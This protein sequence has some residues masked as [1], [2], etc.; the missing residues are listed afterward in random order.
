MTL[1]NPKIAVIGFGAAAIGF[2]NTLRHIPLFAAGNKPISPDLTIYEGSDVLGGKMA[3]RNLGAQFLDAEMFY[4]MDR[5]VKN[6]GLKLLKPRS[7]YDDAPFHMKNRST[8][9]ADD[10]LQAVKKLRHSSRQ[11]LQENK[12]WRDLDNK[13][14]VGFF[15]DLCRQGVLTK[16]ELEA[17]ICRLKLEEG[18]A[19]ISAL[20][21]AINLAKGISP[22]KRV[23]VDGGLHRI[24]E[25]EGARL[26]E[27]GAKVLTS[28]K[29]RRIEVCDTGVRIYVQSSD[30]PEM[31]H[32]ALVAVSPEQLK[33]MEIVNTSF[34]V[35]SL[36]RLSPARITKSNLWMTD[37][38]NVREI[39]DHSYALWKSSLRAD[40][41]TV[42]RGA[43]FFHGWEG[44][45]ALSEGQLIKAAGLT[46]RSDAI[47]ESRTWD[48]HQ[49]N[50]DDLP[51]AYTTMPQRGLGWPVVE[52][53][54]QYLVRGKFAGQRLLFANHV[55][56]AGCYTRDAA[57]A[58]EWAA[59][60]L[61]KSLGLDIRKA[62]SERS[63][64]HDFF[65][66]HPVV[67]FPS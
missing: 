30:K 3:P 28:R 8:M 22:V 36:M 5:I 62:L 27:M 48:N 41:N 59:I 35:H 43:T 37:K 49:H 17:M 18:T 9:P 2:T 24:A 46:K 47:I 56:G 54:Y 25:E 7:D 40:K 44:Q 6:L 51:A 42:L 53:I 20:S 65:G 31:F 58:G 57:L 39:A 66:V 63:P 21:L 61:L 33:T 50:A 34:P 4:P 14:G 29:V 16:R 19:R 26:L 11:I 12:P 38:R 23:E 13:G 60:W 10:F 45:R 32:Y 52:A 15:N 64:F 55:L 67:G 1:L